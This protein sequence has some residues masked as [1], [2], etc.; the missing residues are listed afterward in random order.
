MEKEEID[1]DLK[2]FSKMFYKQDFIVFFDKNKKQPQKPSL[3]LIS[4]ILNKSKKLH[5]KNFLGTL[6]L[7]NYPNKMLLYFKATLQ[8]AENVSQIFT[9]AKLPHT[10]LNENGEKVTF[11]KRSTGAQANQETRHQPT[12]R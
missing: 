1:A 12:P 9:A 11:P 3:S 2:S 8:E 6:A 5:S 10:I 4:G 7:Q